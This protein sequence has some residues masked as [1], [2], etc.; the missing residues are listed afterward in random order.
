[1]FSRK[2]SMSLTA[3][4]RVLFL[5][6][7]AAPSTAEA[8]LFG[9]RQ[10]GQPLSRGGNVGVFSNAGQLQGSA[11]YLRGNRGKDNFI[12]SDQTDQPKFVG[13]IQAKT[14]GNVASATTGLKEPPDQ[15]KQ[16]NQPLPKPADKAL[17]APVLRL[18]WPQPVRSV[19]DLDE[20]FQQALS[21]SPRFSPESRLEV[22]V[23][24]RTAILH[25]EVIFAAERELAENVLR[26]EPGI[27]KVRN[28]LQVRR[29]PVVPSAPPPAPDLLSK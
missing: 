16:L 3:C 1:M 18:D 7:I 2:Y 14:T 4:L 22:S 25:G 17:Y 8:Q 21:S 5:A 15:S 6:V 23:E 29:E 20:K 12:G 28:E 27:S 26:L 19:T 24:G 13:T 9:A 10:I 11:R